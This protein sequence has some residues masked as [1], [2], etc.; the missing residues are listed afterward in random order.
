MQRIVKHL[1]MSEQKKTL[2]SIPDNKGIF[3]SHLARDTLVTGFIVAQDE[4]YKFQTY[5]F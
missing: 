1:N 2:E 3:L 4:A 5:N